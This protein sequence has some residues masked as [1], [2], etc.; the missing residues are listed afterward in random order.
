MMHGFEQQLEMFK[1]VP[2]MGADGGISGV[3]GILAVGKPL[4][5]TLALRQDL[6]QRGEKLRAVHA[7]PPRST[8]S[9]NARLPAQGI[10]GTRFFPRPSV[11]RWLPSKKTD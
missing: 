2:V 1:T 7:R 8:G 6:I 10:V 9:D 11:L 4:Q 5:Q 3:P